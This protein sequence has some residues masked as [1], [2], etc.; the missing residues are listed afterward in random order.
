MQQENA[1]ICVG[2]CITYFK[3]TPHKQILR[4]KI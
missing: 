4:I 1:L 2:I 3:A